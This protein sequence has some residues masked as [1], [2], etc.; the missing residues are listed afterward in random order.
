MFKKATKKQ[1]KMRV[2]MEGASGSGKTYSALT[3]ASSIS[4][5]IAVIDTE[6]GSASL[7]SGEFD[8]D[9]LELQPP[10]EPERFVDA[11]KA[12]ENLGYE[13]I[14][15]DSL[16]HEWKGEGG[17]LDIHKRIGGNSFTA[18]AKVTP[19]HDKF[20][21]AILGSKCHVIGTCR[22]KTE[23][24]LEEGGKK[25]TKQGTTPEQRDGLDF[26][27]TIVFSINQYHM[28]TASKDRTKLFDG[29]DHVISHETGQKLLNW[30]NDG[31]EPIPVDKQIEACQ[32]MQS[33]LALHGMLSPDDQQQYKKQ[34]TDK[35]K[36]LEGDK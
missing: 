18:W 12:A 1:S 11:I 29:K 15:I 9:V 4:D 19:R 5:K 6:H 10:Y 14:I 23:Y 7:Y 24:Q 8:F 33:L 36:Q 20:I 32:S 34:F 2:L 27:M 21:N 16:Y 25:V 28:A 26:E 3:L 35:R 31:E 30:L 22:S 17:C 13:V